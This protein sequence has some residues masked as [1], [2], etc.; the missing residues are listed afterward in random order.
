MPHRS[1]YPDWW[2]C[3]VSHFP[4][5]NAR[6][7]F[8][9]QDRKGGVFARLQTAHSS[10]QCFAL[11]L[12]IGILHDLNLIQ[13]PLNNTFIIHIKRSAQVLGAKLPWQLNFAQWFLIFV[14]PQYGTFFMS[15]LWSLEFWGGPWISGKFVRHILSFISSLASV[16]PLQE[17][18]MKW[19]S[20]SWLMINWM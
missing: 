6:I 9:K 14:G 4:Q 3:R 10:Y 1:G 19:I 5:M 16:L 15:S 2:F 20:D 13:M 18:N 12:G 11:C 7:A 17:D 8:G